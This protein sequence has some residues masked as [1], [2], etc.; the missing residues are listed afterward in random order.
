MY[1]KV[2]DN[3]FAIIESHCIFYYPCFN[4]VSFR[5]SKKA[6]ALPRLVSFSGL[7]SIWYSRPGVKH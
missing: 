4:M 3:V 5:G 6:W 2:D 7:I 1:V